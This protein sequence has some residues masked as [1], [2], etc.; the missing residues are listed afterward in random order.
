MPHTP[1]PTLH[2]MCG[3]IASGKS[4]LS[5][6]LG[7]CDKTVMIAEDD[8]LHALFSDEMA[9]L[10]DFQRC[11]SKLRE[12]IGPHVVSL[13][14]AG[15]SVVLDFQ[16]NTVESRYWMQGIL[17]ETGAYHQLHV[18]EVS[19]EVCL[20]RLRL[21]NASG[22]H[23]FAPT[24]DQFRQFSKYYVAPAE[25]EGFNIVWHGADWA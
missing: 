9:S 23:V 21:R 12:I 24:P 10:S 19:D 11:T 7:R 2:M 1:F 4:T 13:L 17:A 14:N 5:A 8:W 16:A 22:S 6:E 18:L 20:E 25:D 3:K 15:V